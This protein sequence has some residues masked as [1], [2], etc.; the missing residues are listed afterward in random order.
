MNELERISLDEVDKKILRILQESG[1]ISN[2]ELSKKVGLAPSS[3]L[4]RVKNLREHKFIKKVVTVVDEKALGYNV[5]AFLQVELKALTK[6][7]IDEFVKEIT[8]FPQVLECYLTTGEGSF[9]V[10]IIAKDLEYYKEFVLNSLLAL[11]FVRNVSTS[12]IVSVAKDTTIIPI[13]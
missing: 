10:K 3:C 13:D 8:S 4:L 11:P 12:V 5:M 9:L 7:S 6:S 1:D 2:L